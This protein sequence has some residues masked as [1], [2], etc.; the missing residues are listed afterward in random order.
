MSDRLTR[1]A[2]T[3]LLALAT[4]VLETGLVRVF[5]LGQGYHFAFMS[6][7]LA[8]LGTGAGGTL[9]MLWRQVAL[10]P[11]T[12]ADRG[13]SQPIEAGAMTRPGR[14][15]FEGTG[16]ASLVLACAGL[17]LTAIG[18]YL[19][20][21]KLP[22]D[23]YRVAW[24]PVQLLY[25]ALYYLLF[26]L[27]FFFGGLAMAKLL[28]ATESGNVFYA[29]NMLGSAGGCLVALAVMSWIGGPGTV[30]LSA[31]ASCA[32]GIVFA[33]PAARAG[34][35]M[36]RLAIALCSLAG[37]LSLGPAILQVSWFQV[38][39]SPYRPLSYALQFPGARLVQSRWNSFSRVDVVDSNAIHVA[40]GL[41][42][43][44]DGPPPVERGIYTDANAQSTMMGEEYARLGQW[45]DALPMSLAFQLR[46]R[47][48]V[49]VLEPGGGLD[50]AVA[51]SLGAAEV[52]AVSSNS[53]VV[54]AVRD[55][56][57]GLYT[58]SGVRVVVQSPR[59]FVHSAVHSRPEPGQGLFDV[60]DVALLEAQQMVVSGA[61]SYSEDYRYTIQAFV[62]YLAL[63]S[64]NGVLVVQRWLQTPPSEC[65]RAWSLMVSALEAAGWPAPQESLVAVRSWSTVLI[66]AK[67]GAFTA[68]EL[69][70]VRQFSTARQFDLV[71]LP[72][73]RAEEANQ[74][75]IYS[76]EPYYNSFHELLFAE[77]RQ[78]FYRAQVYDVR[79][80]RDDWPFYLNLFRWQQLPEVWR[81]LGHTWQP[82]GG[83]GYL[84]LIALLGVAALAAVASILVPAWLGGRPSLE[85]STGPQGA[86][87][88]CAALLGIAYLAV[89][90]PLIQRF[91]L[92][93]DHPTVAFA[94][95]V[96]V[97]LT[98]SGAGSLLAPRVCT[99]WSIPLLVLYVLALLVALPYVF[100]VFLGSPLA[101]RV[102][103]TVGLVVPL[104][105]LMGVPFPAILIL[106]HRRAPGAT[107]WVWGI[108][109]FAS[110][111]ASI[112]M[113]MIALSWGF[114]AGFGLAAMAYVAVWGLMLRT[115][116]VTPS[117]AQTVDRGTIQE[118]VGGLCR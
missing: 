117:L 45:S 79:P 60:V 44:Y 67:R 107:A 91:V 86:L 109:G 80:P 96:A 18:G 26:A 4:L 54:D 72:G 48:R 61:Y 15:G 65:L 106:V 75:N 83:G 22:F 7:S 58:A 112:L 27:P 90:I 102:A 113:A 49:L 2:G 41:S 69:E 103:V 78:A 6:I 114:A 52:T 88:A 70:A 29:A 38:H 50:V 17:A 110:V 92:F 19:L 40:P 12:R 57:A 66:M 25:L 21:N 32:A 68:S 23:V 100:S 33:W 56:G 24:E 76:G 74:Y 9:L 53:L 47:A 111:V 46:P 94:T 101:I 55:F 115:H 8:L 34:H 95:V 20:S 84:V 97:L 85:G 39:V 116:R 81:A 11:A 99:R 35:A 3:F 13:Q 30:A 42:L 16:D 37:L 73:M 87:L 89:E 82:F 93:L 5:A 118:D 31:V 62:D 71:Y 108:N 105:L 64:D 51:R 98:A 104:G 10:R 43:S 59:S 14:L 77:D 36:G 1:L 63:L 28:E